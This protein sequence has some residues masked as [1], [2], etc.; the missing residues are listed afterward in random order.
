MPK[1]GFGNLIAL[2]FQAGPRKAGNSLFLNDDFEP[3]SWEGQ[4]QFLAGL[5]RITSAAIADVANEARRTGRVIGVR[6]P[7]SE[8]EETGRA[9]W[10]PEPP[11]SQRVERLPFPIPGEV[12]AVLAGRL[13]ILKQ[14]LPPS[15]L[16]R[17][18]RLAAFQNPEFYKRQSLR[19]PT[20]LTPRVIVCAEEI[21]EHLALPRG[22]RAEVEALLAKNDAH[23][24]CDDRR[25]DGA[26]VLATFTG[27]LTDVQAQAVAGIVD[28]QIG[29]LVAPPGS[30]KTVMGASLI[31]KRALSTLI[32]VHRRPLLDQW[33]NQLAMFLGRDPA[34]IG[35]I[36]GGRRKPTGVLDVAM[37]QCL[38][39]KDVVDELVAGYGHVIV[40]ECH[41]V[42]A[43]SF[44]R[45]MNQVRARY[46]LGLTAT[47][48]RRDGHH[49][50]GEMQLGPIRHTIDAKAATAARPFEHKLIVRETSFRSNAETPTMA[51]LY[52]ELAKD[53]VRN[54]TIAQDVAQALELGRVPLVLTERREHVEVMAD[55]IEGF[56]RHVVVMKGG[57]S[58]ARKSVIHSEAPRG[59]RV[60]VATGRFVGEGFDYPSLDSLFLTMPISW[61]GTLVQYA[62]RIQ[63]LHTA[64]REV[65][66]YDYVDR[67][68]P[69]LVRM[70]KRRMRGY[71]AIGY[72][73]AELPPGCGDVDDDF[74]F[75]RHYEEDFTESADDDGDM[76]SRGD[77]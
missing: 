20:G 15:L 28:H 14:G 51:G 31:A 10:D 61:T 54:W 3:F 42:P 68:V 58:S 29:V 26:E 6:S 49:P 77:G 66:I 27:T 8:P 43:V 24:E 44:E 55:L 41:H 17:F 65:R 38:I 30:G 7:A 48:R 63:R 52:R 18:R 76:S 74:V 47:P 56:C 4:W 13:F 35:Q 39:R 25:V 53:D 9:P 60:I 73:E 40:D 71:R 45:V 64:K 75:G 72:T 1:G 16:S 12:K 33:V 50:I 37:I 22:C 70:F 46:V 67:E 69:M 21:G 23:L 2:P 11:E 36:R 57:G 5:K 34:T 59:D 19:L 62:G 32:L